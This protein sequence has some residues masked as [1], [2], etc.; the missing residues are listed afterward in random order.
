MTYQSLY[1]DVDDRQI[2]SGGGKRRE[3]IQIA[4]SFGAEVRAMQQAG[5]QLEEARRELYQ[6]PS[7][8]AGD[9]DPVNL[10]GRMDPVDVSRN[11][12]RQAESLRERIKREQE[13]RAAKLAAEAKEVKKEDEEVKK[14]NEDEETK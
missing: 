5:I 4:T 6:D 13:T 8:D 7:G 14:G 12:S 1:G 9:L 11:Y 10:Y 2:E 3:D